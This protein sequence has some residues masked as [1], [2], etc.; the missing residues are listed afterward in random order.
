MGEVPLWYRVIRAA[1][2]LKVAPWELYERSAF[3]LHAAEAAQSVEQD[4]ERRAS[5][6]TG[7]RGHG[8]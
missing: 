4:A 2:Y 7:R 3:W 1:R 6:R 5:E 8:R